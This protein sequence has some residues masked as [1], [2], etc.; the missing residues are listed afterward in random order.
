[1]GFGG[2]TVIANLQARKQAEQTLTV[3]SVA[4]GEM[5]AG[6]PT[7]PFSYVLALGADNGAVEGGG[8]ASCTSGKITSLSV[9]PFTPPTE[10]P[11]PG[12]G[13]GETGGSE[14]DPE[15]TPEPEP[16]P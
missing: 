7:Y 8:T 4:A 9:P 12:G 6:E 3:T 2:D 16:T 5:K 11:A 15:P 13:E 10:D 1:E 14:S